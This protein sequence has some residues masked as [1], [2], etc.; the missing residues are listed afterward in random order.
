[1]QRVLS[2]VSV[3][4]FVLFVFLPAYAEEGGG[5]AYYDLGVFAYEDGRP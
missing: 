2:Y 4:L 3:I 1:M 5:V